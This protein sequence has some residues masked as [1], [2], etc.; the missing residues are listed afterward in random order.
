VD[1]AIETTQ[2]MMRQAKLPE[3]LIERLKYG[4]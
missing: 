4:W 3:P 2:E 1:Y